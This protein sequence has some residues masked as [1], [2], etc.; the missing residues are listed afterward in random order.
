MGRRKPRLVQDVTF[1][2]IA[3]KGQ[4]VGRTPDGQVVF[5]PQAAP[6]DVAD[7]MVTRRKKGFLQ[8]RIQQIQQ[9]SIDRTVPFCQHFND[10]GG[11]RW[12][13]ITY[14]A[15]LRHKEIVVRDAFE[16][17]AKVAVDEWMPI[18]PAANT[19]YYR[20]KLE[21]TFSDRAWLTQ[22]EL[23]QGVPR[24]PAGALGF[25]LPGRF[26]HIVDIKHCWLQE[27][28]TNGLRLAIKAIAIDQELPF[29]N[30]RQRSGLLRQMVVRVM[31]TGEVMLIVVFTQPEMDKIHRFFDSILEQFPQLTTVFY[32]INDKLN[33]SLTGVE[34][35]CYH[36]PGYVEEQL[37]KVRFR[38]GPHSFFQT[39]TRQ[40]QA[41]YDTVVDFAGLKGSENVYDLYTGLG[42]IALYL[43][44]RCR[45]VVGI[46]EV[47]AAVADARVNA[48]LNQ[49]ENAVF[50]AGDV[51]DILTPAFADRHG[52]PDVLV[53]DP[54]RA[55]MHAKVAQM[56]LELR[57]PL[58][59]YVSCNPATQARDLQ[60]L[61][62]QYTV[63]RVRPVDMF[64]QTSHI[65]NVALLEIK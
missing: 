17:I 7:V 1:T 19:K 45:Q 16:R 30:V 39:N 64:P 59:V 18:L 37:G 12:Q 62:D 6:G 26:D 40:G 20:N 65:E 11:C 5:V 58:I 28:P 57:S 60:L 31:T 43:A 47:E 56:L 33:D 14:E 22:E 9:P 46:E 34:M 29:Y 52:A 63:R 48:A 35:H 23:E 51:K 27:E 25:H 61:S 13:H 3:A 32:G 8:G 53:T 24:D 4:C 36:G 21:F 2:G 49:I 10:C 38:I 54:P 41:L 55:G 42:S 15:Q 50:Y 44:D